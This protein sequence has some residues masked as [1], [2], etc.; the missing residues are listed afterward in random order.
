MYETRYQLQK[1][2]G[3][4]NIITQTINDMLINNVLMKRSKGTKNI[5]REMKIETVKEVHSD[6][7]LLKKN[8]E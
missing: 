2:L 7:G 5:W 6:T 8:A 4:K 3:E 1:I